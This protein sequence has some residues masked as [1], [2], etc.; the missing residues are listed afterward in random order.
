MA[1]VKN[2]NEF[3]LWKEVYTIRN[4]YKD[5]VKDEYDLKKVTDETSKLFNKYDNTDAHVPA[6]WCCMMLREM[7]NEELMARHWD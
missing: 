5:E 1:I 3:N 2:S 4:K 6:L 7:F